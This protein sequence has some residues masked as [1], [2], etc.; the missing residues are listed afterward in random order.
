VRSR[1][2]DELTKWMVAALREVGFSED[3][4]A[5]ETYDSQVPMDVRQ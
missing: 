5:A 1:Y 2:S 4:S 3:R